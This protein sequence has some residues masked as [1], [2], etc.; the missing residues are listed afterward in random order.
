MHPIYASIHMQALISRSVAEFEKTRS[1]KDVIPCI[2]D[3]HEAER[4]VRAK[5][6]G[7]GGQEGLGI[8]PRKL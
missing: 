1:D 2:Q 8:V 5:C 6:A 3:V 7:L 4:P